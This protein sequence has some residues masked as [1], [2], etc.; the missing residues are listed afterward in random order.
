METGVHSREIG[1]GRP[2][3]AR[4]ARAGL[5][6]L[7]ILAVAGLAWVC[8][9]RLGLQEQ[10]AFGWGFVLLILC[11]RW[12]RFRNPEFQR[13]V[14]ILLCL[15]MAGRYWFFRT[16]Y[17]L[18][19]TGPA[20]F[21]GMT[22]LYL[23]ECYAIAIFL[24][25]A[26][27]NVSPLRREPI[28]TA[29]G[30]DGLPT[31]DVFIPTYSEPE[32][33]VA[34]TATAATQ[35]DYPREKL[36]IYILDDGATHQK[37]MDPDPARALQALTRHETLRKL[38]EFLEIHYTTRGKNDH[39]KA[40]NLNQALKRTSHGQIGSELTDPSLLADTFG[41]RGA[42]LVLVLDC[43]HVPTRDFLK[44]TVGFFQ[45]DEKLFLV[46]TPHFFINPD[47][48]ERNLE[49]FLDTPG[50]NEMFY[51]EVLP[52]LDFWESAFFCGS[53]A[54]LRRRCL[55]EAG[56]IAGDTIT[57][58]AETA[59]S[60]HASG[61]RSA[62]CAR[63]MVCG[64]S[65][66]TFSDFVLQRNRWAQG[67]TQI[68]LLKNPLFQKGLK[69]YQRLAYLNTCGFW[70]FGLARLVFLMAP[71]LYL[72][73]GLRIYNA[74]IPQVAAYALPY[75]AA[76]MLLSDFMFG[77]VRRPFFSELYE[78]VLSLYNVPAV[79]ST[80]LRPRS[81]RFKVTP[82]DKSL[83]SD[84]VSPLALPFYL[85]LLLLLAAYPLALYRWVRFPLEHDVLL[86]VLFWSTFNL[87]F[88]FLCMGV[89]AERKQI[90]RRHRIHT[91]EELHIRPAG[92]P[93][94]I[95]ATLRDLSEDGAGLEVEGPFPV[96]TGDRIELLAVDSQGK[97]YRIPAEVVRIVPG[98][99]GTFL[100]CLFVV[101][102][103]LTFTQIVGFVYGDSERWNRFWLRR[104]ET[105]AGFGRSV[106]TLFLKGVRGLARNLAAT[107]R[108]SFQKTR[109]YGVLLW[110]TV[111]KKT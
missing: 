70:F 49:T 81:P 102:D 83:E 36:N 66:E 41:E 94:K 2:F 59:L 37:R 104:R 95:R 42:D 35:M 48:V 7:G 84:F 10:M 39:A 85:L 33:I 26:F 17:T 91:R 43:D 75:L 89:V 45:R 79:V 13:I 21:L 65:P 107:A 80:F 18:F 69:L 78:S 87:V 77:K 52:G 86:I 96:S 31:V 29:T 72:F 22:L 56:G 61:Y 8:S 1:S 24:L 98:R 64:L 23:A 40:G 44:N 97:D 90:R 62:Y 67:M 19:Y 25:S 34:I 101:E 55:Q 27:V 103:E 111:V 5:L 32:E 109:T 51:G 108:L 14:L 3:P 63:P 110:G 68:L 20:D 53:A 74:T 73:F 30:D 4:F 92:E 12:S 71:L 82:K 76:A 47:P 15:I 106:G 54:L 93:G 50:E 38:A 99:A 100:G 9:V 58:D 46:Q 57:E 11:V 88:V 105:P 60:L 28:P 16:G 6:F